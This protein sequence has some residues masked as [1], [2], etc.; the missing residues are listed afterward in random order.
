MTDHN[1]GVGGFVGGRIA[2]VIGGR[3]FFPAKDCGAELH[4]GV[5][6]GPVGIVRDGPILAVIIVFDDI[7]EFPGVRPAPARRPVMSPR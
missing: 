2:G 6:A 5:G 7:S 3:G 4:G 1:L